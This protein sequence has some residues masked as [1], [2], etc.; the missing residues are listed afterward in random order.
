MEILEEVPD[1]VDAVTLFGHNPS[2]TE[3]PDRLSSEGSEFMTK[4]A[5]VCV[6]FPVKTWQEIRPGTGSIVYFIKPQKSV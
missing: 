2:F 4:S 3:L 1:E 5:I 6:S